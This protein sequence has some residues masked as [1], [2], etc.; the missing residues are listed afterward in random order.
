[1][2][3]E[4]ASRYFDREFCF[5]ACQLI[6]RS[7]R[8]RVKGSEPKLSSGWTRS[9]PYSS[10]VFLTSKFCF[11]AAK[12]DVLSSARNIG[13]VV[14]QP[15]ELY[16][17][18]RSSNFLRAN[19]LTATEKKEGKG[20][21]AASRRGH[22]NAQRRRGISFRNIY[23]LLSAPMRSRFDRVGNKDDIS[24]DYTSTLSQFSRYFRFANETLSG[25]ETT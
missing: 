9:L 2:S 19:V 4:K 22:R 8:K 14:T 17:C 7:T 25:R 11:S 18:L 24:R 21:V 10:S 1:M 3:R 23:T 12:K 5:K 15:P 16:F 13:I 6:L 20:K